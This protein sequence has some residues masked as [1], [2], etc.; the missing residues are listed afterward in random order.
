M[1]IRAAHYDFFDLRGIRA[2]SFVVGPNYCITVKDDDSLISIQNSAIEQL[3]YD[4]RKRQKKISYD[5]KEKWLSEAQIEDPQ[6][7][8]KITASLF[9]GASLC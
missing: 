1:A 7:K 5:T 4:V 8:S 3:S 6:K 2:R 9:S